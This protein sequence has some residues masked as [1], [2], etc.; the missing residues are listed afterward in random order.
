MS[1]LARRVARYR[2]R[3]GFPSAV[4]GAVAGAADRAQPRGR[5]ASWRSSAKRCASG[6]PG[7]SRRAAR[8][9]RPARIASRGIRC[10]SVRRSSASDSR[11]RRRAV[12]AACWWSRYLAITLT[13]AMRSEEAHLTEKFG[14]AYPAYREGRAPR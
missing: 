8:S 11:S 7:I 2:V 10:I 6:R 5:R 9:P 4:A 12:A 1:E 14:A 3:L 13:A